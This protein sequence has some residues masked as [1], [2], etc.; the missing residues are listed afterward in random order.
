MVQRYCD[1]TEEQKIR[2]RLY[3]KEYYRKNRA[4]I[5]RKQKIIYDNLTIEQK[6]KRNEYLKEY[7][8]KYPH[9]RSRNRKESRI[10]YEKNKEK[11]KKY[12]RDRYTKL[13]RLPEIPKIPEK[14]E[15]F[16]KIV[17]PIILEFS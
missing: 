15:N 9:K 1:L 11:L 3:L 2:R 7:F 10:Y 8:K 4:E 16:K 17:K 14:I 5:R 6:A 13:Y 12:Q